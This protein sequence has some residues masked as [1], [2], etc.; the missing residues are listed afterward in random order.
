MKQND[1]IND[2][3][4][5][6]W[7]NNELSEKELI[8]F[9]QSKDYHLYVKIAEKSK[10]F[11]IPKFNQEKVYQNIQEKIKEQQNTKVVKLIP[12]WVYSVA[13]VLV[14]A[15][16][17]SLFFNKN[18]TIYCKQG[19]QLAYVLPD[20]S[21]VQLNGESN[22]SFNKKKWEKDKRN[23]KLKG[24]A[25]FKVQKGS[26]FS[27]ETQQGTVS[28]L[29]TQFNVKSIKNYLS[30]ECYEG[31]VSVVNNH[32]QNILTPGKAVVLHQQNQQKFN[33]YNNTPLWF[34]QQYVYNATPLFVVFKD[35]KNI[36]NIEVENTNVDLSQKYTGKLVTHNLEKDLSLVCIPMDIN[37]QI[38][39]NLVKIRPLNE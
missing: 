11:S 6:K 18:T 35:L 8:D 27:V 25:F 7:L 39:K 4:L 29:G 16:G 28:V 1:N 33:I 32:H 10:S 17:L 37:F 15:F 31:K 12:N 26:R 20:G 38:E 24:E 5:A 21:N 9:K 14:I 2:T 23:L 3:F 19:E 22:I 30:V 13:A 36:Y 34:S